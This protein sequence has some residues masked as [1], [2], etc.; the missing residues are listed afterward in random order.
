ME[1]FKNL[2]KKKPKLTMYRVELKTMSEIY[3]YATD[4]SDARAK[5]FIDDYRLH[6]V[7]GAQT[8]ISK[9]EKCD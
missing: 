6:Y 5:T 4:E 8:Q 7:E 2:F 9:V 3:V 1:W